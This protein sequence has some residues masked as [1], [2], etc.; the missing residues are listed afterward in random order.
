MSTPKGRSRIS[1]WRKDLSRRLRSKLRQNKI[2]VLT[3]Y[4]FVRQAAV[5]DP[6]APISSRTINWVITMYGR[7]SGGH[8]NIFRFIHFL[9]GLG[10]ECRIVIVG[11]RPADLTVERAKAD[12]GSW[13]FALRSDVFLGLENAPPASVTMATGWQ[14]AYYVR[15]F[16]ATR[17][18]CYFVQDFEP[19][20]YPSGSDAWFAEQTYQFGFV[21]ITAGSW[22]ADKLR[23]EYGMRTHAVGFSYDHERYRPVPRR[24]SKGRQVFFYARPSTPRRAFELGL[25]VLDEVVRRL[26]DVRIVFAGMALSPYAIPFDHYDAGVVDLD[27]LPELYSNCDVALVLSFSN[28]SLLPLELMACGTPVVSNR[29][30]STEW[31]LSEDNARLAEPTISGLAAA[32]CEVLEHPAERERLRAAGLATAVKTSWRSEAERLGRVLASLEEGDTTL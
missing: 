23:S 8:L 17:H 30:P 6:R 13:F 28:L 19:W 32:V 22:L 12:I 27:H 4:D 5:G 18:K 1:R 24:D 2:D 20:F 11:K 3:A 16:Q 15:N 26:P 21:G 25:L 29:G 7:S 10:F 14:T 31:L 9:E